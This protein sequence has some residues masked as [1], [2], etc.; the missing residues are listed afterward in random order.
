MRLSVAEYPKMYS[1][2]MY[3][4]NGYAYTVAYIKD[5]NGIDVHTA[6]GKPYDLLGGLDYVCEVFYGACAECKTFDKILSRLQDKLCE[7]EIVD[8]GTYC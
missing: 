7:I 6:V 3:G 1:G 4:E 2:K 5:K 8:G